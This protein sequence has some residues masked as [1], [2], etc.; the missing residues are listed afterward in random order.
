VGGYLTIADKLF[1]VLDECTV[2]VELDDGR[3]VT[4]LAILDE[5][6]VHEPPQESRFVFRSSK[7][8]T[9]FEWSEVDSS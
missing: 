1:E 9:G 4:G 2:I 3:A 5:L 6:E 8:L 7:P